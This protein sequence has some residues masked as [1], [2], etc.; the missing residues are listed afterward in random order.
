MRLVVAYLKFRQPF[1]LYFVRWIGGD[2]VW[3][4]TD[5]LLPP[6]SGLFGLRPARLNLIGR[7]MDT[8]AQ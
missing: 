6:G 4:H 3:P 5:H 8:C 2:E 7:T 1:R